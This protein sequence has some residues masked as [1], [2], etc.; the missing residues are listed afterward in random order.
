MNRKPTFAKRQRETDLKERARAKQA[1][2]IA[3]A[4]VSASRPGKGPEIAWDEMIQEGAELPDEAHAIAA[5]N[6]TD[7]PPERPSTPAPITPTELKT[8]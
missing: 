5:A 7:T 4:Q 8:P 2:G 3:R 1:R 6:R